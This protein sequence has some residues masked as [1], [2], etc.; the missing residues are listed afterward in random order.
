MAGF[1]KLA[2][3]DKVSRQSIAVYAPYWPLLLGFGSY[4]S[5][6]S[7]PLAQVGQRQ[8][9]QGVVNRLVSLSLLHLLHFA[10]RVCHASRTLKRTAGITPID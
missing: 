4:L 5:H 9:K 6:D 8:V 7:H 3:S 10:V 2:S 1:L